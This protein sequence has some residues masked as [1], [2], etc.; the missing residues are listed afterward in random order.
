MPQ[1]SRTPQQLFYYL[2]HRILQTDR[3]TYFELEGIPPVTGRLVARTLAEDGEVERTSPT[4]GYDEN[5][6]T[7][8]S[9]G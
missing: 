4:S 3:T 2:K 6:G 5:G 8:G 7:C 1:A 9:L